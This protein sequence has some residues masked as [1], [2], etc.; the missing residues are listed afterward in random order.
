[1]MLFSSAGYSP[2]NPMNKN[3]CHPGIHMLLWKDGLHKQ[4]FTKYVSDGDSYY[5]ESAG[6][7]SKTRKWWWGGLQF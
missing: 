3:P 5:G 1:M 6:Q 4:G 2:G 7:R